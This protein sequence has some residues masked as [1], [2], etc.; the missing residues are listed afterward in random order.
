MIQPLVSVII[1]NY[2][3]ARYLPQVLDSV[4]AQSYSNVEIIVV[5][6]GSMDDSKA[7]LRNYEK[8]VRLV[9]QPNQGVSAARNRGVRESSGELLAFLDADDVWL[10]LK[11]ERQ[12]GR[13]LNQ[14]ELGLV[15]CGVEDISE[16]GVTRQSHLDGLEGWVAKDMLLFRRPVILGGGSGLV[17]P[18]AT[19]E[20]LG[21]FDIRLSTSADWDFCCR[22]AIR[23]PVGF[24]PEVLMQ[25]RV[26]GT[27]MHGN[28]SLMERDMLLAYSKAFNSPGPE[29]QELRR[30]SYGNLHMTLAGSFFRSGRYYDFTRHALKSLWLTPYNYVRILGFPLRLWNR[31]HFAGKVTTT[32]KL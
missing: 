12:V 7:V 32:T 3:Y 23:Q 28:I 9:E 17:I 14:P 15:H 11:L 25:Y 24:V 4:L 29:L 1:P 20:S 2:N 5:D 16:T 22:V 13:F 19:F 26:H 21:G 10:P 27:N 8:H 18:R 31:H 6:D 30:Q